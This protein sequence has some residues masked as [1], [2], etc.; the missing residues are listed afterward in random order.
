MSAAKSRSIV[1]F[2][3]AAAL[4]LTTG[5]VAADKC[6]QCG[7]GQKLKKTYRPVVTFK[8]YTFQCWDY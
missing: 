3:A 2:V 1:L 4:L 7:C 8:K 6:S 5:A